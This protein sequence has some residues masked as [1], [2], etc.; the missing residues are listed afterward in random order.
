MKAIK[1]ITY[2]CKKCEVPFG[3]E[4]RYFEDKHGTLVKVKTGDLICFKCK[5]KIKG[6]REYK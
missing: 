2:W 4:S 3:D 6:N 5:R 1:E